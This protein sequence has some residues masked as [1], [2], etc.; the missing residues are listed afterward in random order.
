MSTAHPRS[1]AALRNP[2]FRTIFAL[3]ATTMMA[4]NIEH[5][6]SYWVMYQKFQSPTL[7]GLAMITHWIPYLLLSVWSGVLADR[8]DVRRLIQIGLGLFMAATIGWGVMFHSD[9]AQLWHAAVLLTI[10]GIAGVFWIPPAMVL[11]QRT[12]GPTELQSAVRLN[13]T[14]MMLGMFLGPAVGGALMLTLGPAVGLVVNG[15]FYV[16]FMLWLMRAPHGPAPG[17]AARH[18]AGGVVDTIRAIAGNRTVVTMIVLAGAASF[19]VGNGFTPQMPEF[20]HDLH[21]GNDDLSYSVLLGA[22]AAGALIGGLLLE[23]RSL[24]KPRVGTAIVLAMLWSL[25]IAAF[26]MTGSYPVAV[27]L[28]MFAGFVNLS[29]MSMAQTLVQLNAPPGLQGRVAG[30]YATASN[31]MRAFSGVTIGMLGSVIGVHS[32]LT[33][34]AAALLCAAMVLAAIA[35]RQGARGA[36]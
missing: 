36:H 3:N 14:G 6:I 25:S 35:L 23:S 7:G 8:Y 29:F 17:G 27:A 2:G 4:D 20:A 21:T 33:L 31:G 1:F 34:S 22:N 19:F 30:L 28:M 15:L 10:H 24:L 16:P 9:S 26:A 13:A 12:V 18:T 5:V 11:I 32:S